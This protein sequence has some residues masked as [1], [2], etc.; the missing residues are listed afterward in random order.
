MSSV[1]IILNEPDAKWLDE[2]LQSEY[3]REGFRPHEPR[4]PELQSVG[5]AVQ[6]AISPPID[7]NDI[8]TQKQRVIA[9]KKGWDS[10]AVKLSNFI[11]E[12]PFFAKLGPDEQERLKEQCEIMWQYS[13]ILGKRIAAFAS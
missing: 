9:E 13:E 1:I 10:R 6:A 11:G 4:K 2:F 12:N 5:A 7:D 8:P 3:K